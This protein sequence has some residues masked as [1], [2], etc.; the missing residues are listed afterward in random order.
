MKITTP[1]ITVIAPIFQRKK[2]VLTEIKWFAQTM[3]FFLQAEYTAVPLMY[4][5]CSPFN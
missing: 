5:I 3:Y 4:Y 2:Q 1:I